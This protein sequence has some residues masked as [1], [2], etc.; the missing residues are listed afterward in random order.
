MIKGLSMKLKPISLAIFL[1]VC[2]YSYSAAAAP[3]PQV[4]TTADIKT[5][6]PTSLVQPYMPTPNLA[7][8]RFGV[9]RNWNTG[10]R[11]HE[12]ID[13]SG[14]GEQKQ[15]LTSDGIYRYIGSTVWAFTVERPGGMG[16][17]TFF[18]SSVL[19]DP[20]TKS[21]VLVKGG[22]FGGILG[23]RTGY[24]NHVHY[25]Y[26]ALCTSGLVRYTG[27]TGA[28]S[29]VGRANYG[30]GKNTPLSTWGKVVKQSTVGMK[31]GS[32][33]L[34]SPPQ[35]CLTDPAPYLPSDRVFTGNMQDPKLDTYLGNSIY[36]QYNVLYNANLP[37]GRG[38]PGAR[39]GK[40]GFAQLPIYDNSKLTP[41]QLANYN[42]NSV[43]GSIMA[44]EGGYNVDGQLMSQQMMA[45]IFSSTDGSE[46]S[47]LPKPA[48]PLDITKMSMKQIIEDSATKRFG[49][50]KWEASVVG[51][52]S[53]AMLNEYLAM[54]AESNFLQQQNSRLKNRIEMLL[55]GMTQ[56][57]LFEFN[58]K[59][60]AMS[61]VANASSV[62]RIID[63]ELAQLQGYAGSGDVPLNIPPGGAAPPDW[64]SVNKDDLNQIYLYMMKSISIGESTSYEAFNWGTVI[65]GGRQIYCTGFSGDDD[66]R[67]AARKFHGGVNVTDLTFSEALRQAKKPTD[68]CGAH[69][70]FAHGKYQFTPGTLQWFMDSKKRMSFLNVKYT[71][72]VQEYT[73][74]W[75][76]NVKIKEFITGKHSNWTQALRAISGGWESI[77]IYDAKSGKYLRT[78]GGH[79]GE[80]VTNDA[81]SKAVH[82]ALLA[83][84]DW[85]KK[86][87]ATKTVTIDPM[88]DMVIV[89]DK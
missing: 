31:D 49:N 68:G 23:N 17:Y 70:R 3:P 75:R 77:G 40:G 7:S 10:A 84:I 41:D 9:W 45:S 44:Q 88:T 54:E 52:S 69:K 50:D 59:I 18:H 55:A 21:N 63:V 22:S 11:Y 35:Y 82:T 81:P 65:S 12:G 48:E 58:K 2:G 19:P 85:H 43:N 20:K 73:A 86:Y 5:T 30:G 76:A 26:N 46:W 29:Q 37:V 89:K 71:P 57:Q 13:F 39:P 61:I 32:R 24:D 27:V 4:T 64:N 38:A 6:P 25:Q 33:V 51:L 78:V 42:M 56:A 1:V 79:A 80:P 53:K 8:W 34:L 67:E 36:G 15:T 74:R 60:E 72:D 87:G 47:T 62:P 66:A 28:R 14:H 83:I 16:T